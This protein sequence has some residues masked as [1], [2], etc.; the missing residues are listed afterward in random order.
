MNFHRFRSP[1]VAAMLISAAAQAQQ[2]NPNH[3]FAWGENIGFLN[4][5]DAG[6]PQGSQGVVADT[7]FL[8]GYVWGENIGWINLGGGQGPYANTTGLN[9]GVNRDAATGHLSGYAWAENIGWI[10][11]SGGALANPAKPARIDS[12][13]R[14]FR[15]YAWGENVGWINLDDTNTF[16]GLVC[17]ADLNA[18]GLLNFFDVALYITWYNDANPAADLAAPFDV[19]NFFDLAAYITLY[20]AG[21]P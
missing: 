20:N 10:N 12:A 16:V 5:A 4:F 18:D 11:F 9:F 7:H 14:R 2:I 6:S 8:S 21:C 15:G 13:S 19:L 1:L 17:G 3:K